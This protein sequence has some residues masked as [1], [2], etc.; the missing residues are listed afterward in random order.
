MA[1]QL[2]HELYNHNVQRKTHC[3]LV[4]YT[5]SADSNKPML[6]GYILN[7]STHTHTHTH[8]DK[9]THISQ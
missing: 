2:Q 6:H 1:I 4:P 9:R 3:T 7:E 5:T 8:S